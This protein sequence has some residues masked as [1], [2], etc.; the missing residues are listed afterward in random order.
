MNMRKILLAILGTALTGLTA[1]ST[2]EIEM[3]M[4]TFNTTQDDVQKIV[5]KI[6]TI[7]IADL[8]T[9]KEIEEIFIHYCE[10][11][12]D[13]KEFVTNYDKLNSY[14]E[15][16]TKL[17]HTEEKQGSR[18]DRSNVNIGTYCF[19]VWTEESVQNL[20]NCGIDFI[21]NASYNETLLN[22]LDQ[23]GVGA[24]VSGAIPGWYSGGGSPP[25]NAGTMST[26]QPVTAY[27][28]YLESYVDYDCIWAIDL[29][30]EPSPQDIPHYGDII[31]HIKDT[32]PNQLLYLNLLPR[33]GSTEVAGT[34]YADHLYATLEY[35][36][37]DYLCYDRYPY[38]EVK[39]DEERYQ[40]INRW[41]YNIHEANRVC[42]EKNVDLWIVIAASNY[43]QGTNSEKYNRFLREDEIRLQASLSLTYGARA[44]SWA[45]WNA[46]WFNYHI[47]DNSGNPSEVYYHVQKVNEEIHKLSPIYSRYDNV[48]SGYLGIDPSELYSDPDH[49][50]ETWAKFNIKNIENC[51]IKEI[52][53]TKEANI[54]AGYFEK[55]E[56]TGAAIMLTNI[57]DYFCEEDL[58][59]PVVFTVKDP[60]AKVVAY[61]NGD[62]FEPEHLGNGQYKIN[63]RNTDNVF[64][65]ID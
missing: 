61:Y 11:S 27:D 15:E 59:H 54:I 65:T 25:A 56:G 63:I 33:A 42:N 49:V 58:Y 22:L 51:P 46:G 30:D 4:M 34:D 39:K 44:L 18:I 29:G 24:F 10:L 23:Y 1:C 8:S 2:G 41:L 38:H 20:V 9:E 31:E 6:D 17:Y 21:S 16:I 14:R 3:T 48:F 36:K 50:P 37:F 28:P 47:A 5:E 57:S 52:S 53:T 45:C 13:Q 32:F 64:V 7:E 26:V 35:C 55:L 19:N 62:A 12:D 40:H 60:E 43:Q